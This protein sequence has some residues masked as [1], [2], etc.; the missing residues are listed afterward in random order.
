MLTSLALLGLGCRPAAEP[1]LV[2][3]PTVPP[4]PSEAADEGLEHQETPEPKSEPEPE[5]KGSAGGWTSAL[6]SS[7]CEL[8]CA[9]VY[10]CLLLDGEER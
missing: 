10:S 4:S 5:P 8:V 3:A 6:E 2:G 1:E 7:A 9:D